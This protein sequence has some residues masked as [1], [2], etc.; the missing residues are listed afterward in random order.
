MK[1]VKLF[2]ILLTLTPLSLLAQNNDDEDDKLSL[3]EG[4]IDNQFEY[5]IRKSNNYKDYKVV[6]KVWLYELKAHTLDSL[7]AVHKELADTRA[8]VQNQTEEIDGLK[9]NLANTQ[10]TLG[11]TE[12]EKNNMALFGLQM[13]KSSYNVLMWSIIGGLLALLL[14]FIYQFKNSNAVTK[15]AKKSLADIEEEFEEHRRTALEREQKV[16]R[17]LQDEINKQKSGN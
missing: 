13:S 15:S 7:K 16:R 3:Y 11:K 8:V 6:K 17:Q 5:L 12:E 14:F 10:T 4:S 9:A 2:L 1:F